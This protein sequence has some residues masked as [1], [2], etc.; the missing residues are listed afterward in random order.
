MNTAVYPV[1]PANRLLAEALRAARPDLAADTAVVPKAWIKNCRPEGFHIVHRLEELPETVDTVLFLTARDLKKLAESIRETIRSGKNILCAARL[2]EEADLRA[3]AENHG[4][5]AF[6]FNP[7][8]RLERLEREEAKYMPQESVVIAVGALMKN[9]RTTD[10]VLR[11]RNRFAE[12]GYRV[13]VLASDPD[14]R[15][16]GYDYLPMDDLIEKNLDHTIMM[17]N[18]YIN[19]HQGRERGDI[20][21]LQLPDEGLERDSEDYETCFGARTYLISRAASVDCGV[22]LSP[23]MKWDAEL[24]QAFSE[25]AVHRYGFSYDAVCLLPVTVDPMY[26]PQ[27][28]ETVDYYALPEAKAEEMVS[29][30]QN[31]DGDI[32]FLRDTEESVRR[33]ADDLLDRLS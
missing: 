3:L 27:G 31:A 20:I 2:E 10:M 33:L 22:M 11:L 8:A 7:A 12:L 25:S 15:A 16:L 26:M 28:A 17:V 9:I 21:L 32:L 30:L 24:Y 29:L 5:K 19:D 1:T 6:F 23:V 18:R 4:V 13:S 14:L